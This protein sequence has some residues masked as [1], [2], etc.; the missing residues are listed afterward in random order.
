[1]CQRSLLGWQFHRGC[2]LLDEWLHIEHLCPNSW[3]QSKNK[4]DKF[5]P[6]WK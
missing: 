3:A 6:S 4:T 1:M 5:L 2:H